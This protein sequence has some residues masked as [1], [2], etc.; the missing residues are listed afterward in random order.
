[1]ASTS[2]LKPVR[3]KMLRATR[4]DACGRIDYGLCGTVT[5]KGFTTVTYS[6]ET[7]DGEEISVS[8]AAGE[9]CIDI[10]GTPRIKWINLEIEFCEVDPDL[11]LLFFPT[12]EAELDADGNTV[13]F[14]MSTDVSTDT[15]VAFELWSDL[16][17]TSACEDASAQG[18]WGYFLLPW[19]SN[20][21]LGDIEVANDAISFSI[22]ASTKNNSLWGVGPYDVVLD[23]TGTPSPLLTPIGPKQPLLV[24]ETTVAPPEAICGCQPLVKPPT[25]PLALAAT[26][27]PSDS[28]SVVAIATNA[29]G[30]QVTFTWGDASGDTVVDA[31]AY[32]ATAKHTYTSAAEQTVDAAS[33][34]E[35]DTA[36]VTTTA[37]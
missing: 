8:N 12:W 26:V 1:M 20:A 34:D 11:F 30:D 25:E 35:T 32:T 18:A 16:V 17:G 29:K 2:C 13:G 5:S 21:V 27:D 9:S 31:I 28:M 19:V 7:D 22:T 4:L 37:P 3:G 10:P 36:T 23:D 6:M 15:G 33:A 14:R 24:R